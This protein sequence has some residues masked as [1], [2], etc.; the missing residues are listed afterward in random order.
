M[1]EIQARPGTFV[2]AF[3]AIA[4][5][6]LLI[7]GAAG[8]NYLISAPVPTSDPTQDIQ[9][10]YGL[11]KWCAGPLYGRD[12]CTSLIDQDCTATFALATPTALGSTIQVLQGSQCD[13]FNTIR[14]L[15]IIS[16]V[17]SGVTAFILLVF[18]V[19]GRGSDIRVA[20]IAFAAGLFGLISMAI[21]VHDLITGKNITRGDSFGT[22][23]AGWVLILVDSFLIVADA[24][25]GFQYKRLAFANN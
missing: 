1:S 14:G 19:Q 4:A 3:L 17:L 22:A 5:A 12:W 16:L 20:L 10:H 24:V 13:K 21:A 11:F 25:Y 8:Q 2:S 18:Y 6:A 15:L 9:F 23:V 7:A